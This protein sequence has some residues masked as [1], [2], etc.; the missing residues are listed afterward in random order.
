MKYFCHCQL[1][2]FFFTSNV[3]LGRSENIKK[4]RW[5]V[6]T[7]TKEHLLIKKISNLLFSFNITTILKRIFSL[8]YLR[9][10]VS[11]NKTHTK[12]LLKSNKIYMVTLNLTWIRF[13]HTLCLHL[14][15]ESQPFPILLQPHCFREQSSLQLHPTAGNCFSCPLLIVS[16]SQEKI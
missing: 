14:H 2:D 4:E 6:V 12:K 15:E 13:R 11:L 8:F 5:C 3:F 1:S 16:R 10:I 7:V 9:R